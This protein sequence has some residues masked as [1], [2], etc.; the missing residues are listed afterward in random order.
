MRLVVGEVRRRGGEGGGATGGR[1]ATTG[2]GETAGD[3]RGGA[4]KK[5]FTRL[6]GSCGDREARE[7]GTRP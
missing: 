3:S 2:G 5:P 1:G 7:G 6:E 4:G